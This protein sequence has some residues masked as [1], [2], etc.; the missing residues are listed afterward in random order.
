MQIQLFGSRPQHDPAVIERLKQWTAESLQLSA[1]V[2]VLVTE[3]RCA[4]EDCPDVETVIAI[5]DTPGKPRQFKLLKPMAEVSRDEV[6]AA[7]TQP[8]N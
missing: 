2:P 7:L 8:K 4:E 1:D 3:L 5:L 6:L